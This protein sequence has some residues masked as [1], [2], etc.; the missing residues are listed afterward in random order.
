MA[1]NSRVQSIL[2]LDGSSPHFPEQLS[3]VLAKSD[4]DESLQRL[5]A[6]DLALVIETLDKVLSFH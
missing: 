6:D 1:T 2:Q 3:G 5:G 4:F